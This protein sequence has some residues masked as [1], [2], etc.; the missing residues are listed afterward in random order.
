[1]PGLVVQGFFPRGVNAPARL[2]SHLARL[3]MHG[4]QPLPPEV[5]QRME[6]AF[7]QSFAQ[8][9]VHVGRHVQA[10]GALA[11]TQGSNIHFAPGQYSPET[12]QGR[13]LL[14]HELAHVVQQR[15]GRVRSP[16]SDGTAVVQDP[17]LEAEAERM[18]QKVALQSAARL[19]SVQAKSVQPARAPVPPLPPRHAV[20]RSVQPARPNPVR[21]GQAHPGTVQPFSVVPTANILGKM[22]NKRPWFGYPYVIAGGSISFMGQQR[23]DLT[24]GDEFLSHSGAD[25]ANIR[26]AKK[27]TLSLRVSDDGNMAI[28]NSNLTNRQPKVFYATA[29]VITASNDKLRQAGST[30][31]LVRSSH[32]IRVIT[33]WWSAVK[34]LYRV[35]PEFS[36]PPK[37]NC[38][39]IS[40]QV[41]GAWTELHGGKAAV[42]TIDR[43][44]NEDD[45][46]YRHPAQDYLRVSRKVPNRLRDLGA[47]RHARAGVGEAYMITSIGKP[48]REQGGTAWI[49]DLRSGELRKISWPYH[50][51]GVVASSGND[52]IT[53]ENY[54]RGDNRK[55]GF[56]P[57][58]YLQM[59][60]GNSGQTFHEQHA[61]TPQYANPLT[62]TARQEDQEM[63]NLGPVPEP[64]PITIM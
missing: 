53:L 16:F 18:A 45:A 50:F 39:S 13:R 40:E 49:R 33:G 6:L 9:R 21:S 55:N 26:N 34:V 56:D 28:E 10:A 12:P 64:W 47:N 62:V 52:T 15:S 57:R 35:D 20:P 4:G 7:G 2:P 43:L 41:T 27:S 61:A 36:A 32:S 24:D 8:V 1:M 17:R 5:L 19:D 59:Y 38:D 48:E 14:A 11:F 30:V 44:L 63:P 51:A 37:Q 54:A 29:E 31:K 60:G 23:N 46:Y 22:P 3:P 42:A 58:W 25:E